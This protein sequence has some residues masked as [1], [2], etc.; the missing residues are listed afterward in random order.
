MVLYCFLQDDSDQEDSS[1]IYQ[2]V[3]AMNMDPETYTDP[4]RFN[5]DRYLPKEKGGLG[6]PFPVGNFGFGRR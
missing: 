5:P 6:E 3:F 1:I 4:E 2:N